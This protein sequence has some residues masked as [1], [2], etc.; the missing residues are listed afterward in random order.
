MIRLRRVQS[1]QSGQS[2]HRVSSRTGVGSTAAPFR[3]EASCFEATLAGGAVGVSCCEAA[4]GLGVSCFEAARGVGAEVVVLG[5][6]RIMEL[7]DE[8]AD[9]AACS[10]SALDVTVEA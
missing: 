6:S 2:G 7:E 10:Q 1:G 4:R 8:A 5:F 9:S 3:S